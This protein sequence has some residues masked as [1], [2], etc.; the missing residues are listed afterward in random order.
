MGKSPL[1]TAAYF[2]PMIV[3]GLILSTLGGLTLHRLPGRVLLFVSGICH[4]LCVLLFA[5]MPEDANY[6]AYVFPAMIGATGGIDIIYTVSNIF[7]TTKL[8]AQHQGVAGALINSLLFL[9]IGF[10]LSIADIAVSNTAH[11]GLKGSYQ[12]AFWFGVAC[13]GVAL[14]FFAFVDVG[15]AES[16]FTEEEKSQF[17]SSVPPTPM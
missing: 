17:G 6:W 13:A 12:V 14:L 11:T 15:K 3:G 5:L 2:I 9:G 10:F 8:P 4:L 16:E 7:I 1:L